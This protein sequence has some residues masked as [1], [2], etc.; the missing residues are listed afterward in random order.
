MTYIAES[1]NIQSHPDGDATT[2]VVVG[3]VDLATASQLRDAALNALNGAAGGLHLDLTGVT[4][5]DSTGIHVL[6]A[7]RRRAELL[8]RAV[9]LEA[10]RR[11]QRTLTLCGVA[12]LFPV[13]PSTGGGCPRNLVPP[14]RP[15]AWKRSDASGGQVHH[16]VGALHDV[17]TGPLS[18]GP[19]A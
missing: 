11:V 5:M 2:L 6:V 18:G 7:T 13:R 19:A 9:T 15:A 14:N 3:E 10:S 4:F 16:D 1:L 8:G 12:K 17:D